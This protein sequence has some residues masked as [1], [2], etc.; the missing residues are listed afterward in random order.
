MGD[1]MRNF[2]NGRVV[3]RD[4]E[5]GEAIAET[6]VLEFDSHSN[7]LT[8]P[9]GSIPLDEER[10]L[11]LLILSHNV[12]YEYFGNIRKNRAGDDIRIAIFGEKE[13]DE[14]GFPRYELKAEAAIEALV[15]EGQRVVLNRSIPIRIKNI[16]ASGLLIEAGEY[17]LEEGEQI[18]VNIHL[19]GNAFTSKY[20][21]VRTQRKAGRILLYGCRN[22]IRD[23]SQAEAAAAEGRRMP[24][25]KRNVMYAREVAMFYEEHQNDLERESGYLRMMEMTSQVLQMG[26]E[27]AVALLAEGISKIVHTI[28]FPALLNC[29]HRQRPQREERQRHCL[30]V[31]FLCGF[32]AIWKKY[33]ESAMVEL[34]Q[35]SI[36][37]CMGKDLKG[38]PTLI[39]NIVEAAKTYDTRGAH[40][41]GVTAGVPMVY[42]EQLLY[43]GKDQPQESVRGLERELALHILQC[44]RH[45]KVMLADGR[46]AKILRMLP[47]DVAH[48]LVMADGVAEQEND[49][50]NLMWIHA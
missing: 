32:F 30:N 2:R 7:I 10:A 48:P 12:V 4:R 25:R 49:P 41:T 45:K 42:L 21:I 38:E 47:N 1:F 20:E 11:T 44:L 14:R 27:E 50:W 34:I 36:E 8:I 17:E 37:N 23:E 6:T 31:A 35:R 46:T 29:I 39:R 28:S 15:L 43:A 9:R 33:Q 18:W 19:E 3:V 24:E 22:L 5:T 16:S 13:K 40:P 26:K